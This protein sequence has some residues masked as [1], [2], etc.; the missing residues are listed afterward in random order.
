[1][2]SRYRPSVFIVVYTKIK[3]KI[4]YLILKR[5]LHWHGWE[6]PKGGIKLFETHR[7]AVIRELQEETGLRPLGI[8]DLHKFG[9]YRYPQKVS[10]RPGYIGQSY[11]LFAVHVSKGQVTLDTREHDGFQWMTYPAVRRMLTWTDQQKAI[12]IAHA[13]LSKDQTHPTQSSTLLKRK[14]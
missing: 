7:H 12:S 1:M 6:F 8:I 13:F 14:L 5:K 9:K 4:Q 3:G 11:H 2:F 10:D